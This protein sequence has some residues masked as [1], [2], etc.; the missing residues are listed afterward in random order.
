MME[1]ASKRTTRRWRLALAI[2][3]AAK[4][5]VLRVWQKGYWATQKLTP[6]KL[7]ILGPFETRGE[8]I[9]AAKRER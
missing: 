2:R 3:E 7:R 5:A 6:G 1:K 9:A 8:A 4:L